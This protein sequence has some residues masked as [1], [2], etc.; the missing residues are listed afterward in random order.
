MAEEQGFDLRADMSQVE[1]DLKLQD[2]FSRS[3]EHIDEDFYDPEFRGR[4]HT[5][6]G[7]ERDYNSF[8]GPGLYEFLKW[9]EHTSAAE[10][11]KM[12]MP[13][14][15]AIRAIAK[16]NNPYVYEVDDTGEQKFIQ[17]ELK[18]KQDRNMAFDM[19]N[20]T[21]GFTNEEWEAE[22]LDE[23][24]RLYDKQQRTKGR[25]AEYW[26]AINTIRSET[27][28][29]HV[30]K[31]R[32]YQE[33]QAELKNQKAITAAITFDQW[34]EGY[35]KKYGKG[36]I[37]DKQIRDAMAVHQ[38]AFEEETIAR[39]K[40]T[41]DVDEQDAILHGT[42]TK[43]DELLEDPE[44]A[45]SDPEIAKYLRSIGIKETQ[46]R[47]RITKAQYKELSEHLIEYRKNQS[48]A[49]VRKQE[50]IVRANKMTRDLNAGA[51]AHRGADGKWIYDFPVPKAK[52]RADQR[53]K[54]PG[55]PH[56]QLGDDLD[57]GVTFQNP[58]LAGTNQQA[59][60]NGT[61][62][63]NRGPLQNTGDHDH[64]SYGHQGLG[65]GR[66]HFKP[67]KKPPH[68]EPVTKITRTIVTGGQMG[69]GGAT[70]SEN[71][72]DVRGGSGHQNE[73]P[74][75][76]VTPGGT[77]N[78]FSGPASS[79]DHF[80]SSNTKGITLRQIHMRGHLDSKV[81]QMSMT[82]ASDVNFMRLINANEGNF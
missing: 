48:S 37:T 64:T 57:M 25:R 42:F 10:K 32:E 34:R 35:D 9:R 4:I 14:G 55:A 74:A 36:K 28:T 68:H 69:E 39:G 46:G 59:T 65:K 5:K 54:R 19:A 79:E 24:G 51:R 53:G 43:Y 50:E 70:Q 72:E 58:T 17:Y 11:E 8:Y 67:A 45:T 1:K 3:N 7:T 26:K 62:N 82:A 20:K 73:T 63:P 30:D 21:K 76:Q 12:K 27:Y 6:D 41:L 80:S 52:T 22:E 66:N 44:V 71:I 15:D 49:Q 60:N 78:P 18:K 75:H 61:T 31:E 38:R 40:R 81:N 2:M 29:G 23:G 13:I 56:E 16:A 77:T 47:A 33:Q